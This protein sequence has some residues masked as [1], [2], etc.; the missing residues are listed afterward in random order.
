MTPSSNS[1][2]TPVTCA[3]STGAGP[4]DTTPERYQAA[5]LG[6]SGGITLSN[7]SQG[8]LQYL[9]LPKLLAER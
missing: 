4:S 3:D 5:G 2:A 6:G 9:S 7:G 8:K 1:Q